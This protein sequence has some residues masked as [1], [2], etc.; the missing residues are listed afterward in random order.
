M[1]QFEA[2]E[3]LKNF[4]RNH[5]SDGNNSE[6]PLIRKVE[7]FISAHEHIG[8]SYL[9][10]CEYLNCKESPLEIACQAKLIDADVVKL[11][12]TKGAGSRSK[13]LGM[14]L[15]SNFYTTKLY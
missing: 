1:F 11:L 5:S 2:N 15:S 12:L 14:C 7:A 8:E 9:Q 6:E 10:S 3:D 13:E 4:I